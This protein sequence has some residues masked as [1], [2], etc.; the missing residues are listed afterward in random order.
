MSCALRAL[1]VLACAATLYAQAPAPTQPQ[2]LE[3]AW[4]IGPVLQ[5]LADHAGRLL[6]ALDKFDAD[7][8][9]KKGASDTYV[10]QLQS[11]K[12]QARAVA[13]EAKALEANPERLSAGLQ[14]MFRL[15]SLDTM[16]ASLVEGAHRY[17]ENPF[18]TDDLTRVAAEG[19]V[20]RER[21]QRYMVNLAAQQ[22]QNLQ[23]MDREAQRCRGIITQETPKS[24]RKR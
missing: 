20:T 23:V 12:E 13:Q 3:T 8:W 9:V 22:E 24:T 19:G 11:S 5:A 2:G 17:H 10:A 16:L 14:L 4:E 21:I 1:T 15:Q 18:T 7:A 6:K